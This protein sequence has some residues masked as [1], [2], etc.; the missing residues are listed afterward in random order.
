MRRCACRG[1]HQDSR[2]DRGGRSCSRCV[3]VRQDQRVA[4]CRGRAR[5]RRG[6]VLGGR[7]ERAEAGGGAHDRSEGCPSGDRE[8]AALVYGDPTSALDVIGITGTNGKTTT[9]YL[10]AAHAR[11]GRQAPGVIGTI[12]YRFE[13]MSARGLAHHA[14]GRRDRARRRGDAGASRH[15]PRDGG[16][17]ARA[18]AGARG[19]GAFRAAAF[20]NLT[21]DHLDFHG[22]MDGVR[23]AQS[24][25]CFWSSRPSVAV[26]NVDDPFGAELAPEDRWQTCAGELGSQ[27]PR[28][29][30]LRLCRAR[31]ATG[32]RRVAC[33]LLVARST[34]AIR[35]CSARTTSSNLLLAAAASRWRSSIDP[36]VAARGLSRGGRGARSA[37]ALRHVR[38]RHP[39]ARRL[40]AHARRARAR[41]CARSRRRRPRGQARSCVFGCGGD[42]DQGQ[43]TAHGRRR[44][45]SARTSRSSPAT[46]RAPRTPR[47]RRRR[48]WPGLREGGSVLG[49]ELDR[50]GRRSTR[51]I[52][53]GRLPG[54]VRAHRRQ[55]SRGLPDR[56]GSPK[57]T[58][59]TAK[60]RGGALARR[61]AARRGGGR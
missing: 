22:D 19:R 4:S 31:L 14:G 42:R 33:S 56:R 23:D 21:Q 34:A 50:R 20:T 1:V 10:V 28:R 15:A 37:G 5:A 51:A 58:S 12:G 30:S 60:R 52:A 9:S 6:G 57:R 8:A 47:D 11:S 46:T 36:V 27:A 49:V 16:L 55:G 7:G 32:H 61:R 35:R 26:V 43:A 54:D 3:A 38:R 40:R 2:Q 44:S 41:S 29:R 13:A 45:P 59:T 48:S 17:V 39:C 24:R 18:G 25:S 53:C